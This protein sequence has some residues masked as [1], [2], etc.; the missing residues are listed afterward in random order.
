MIVPLRV[1][2]TLGVNPTETSQ[3]VPAAILPQLLNTEKSGSLLLTPLTNS[4]AV[5]VLLIANCC[6]GALLPTTVDG[7]VNAVGA[8]CAAAVPVTPPG[9]P[10]YAARSANGMVEVAGFINA[11]C[12]TWLIAKPIAPG[13]SAP[14]SILFWLRVGSLVWHE[15]SLQLFWPVT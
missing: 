10:M 6:D 2:A 12:V 3:L 4:A 13:S 15:L 8:S 9:L 5:P 7:N 11:I 1:P 14:F